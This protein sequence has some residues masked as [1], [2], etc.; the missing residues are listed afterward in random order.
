[1]NKDLGRFKVSQREMAVLQRYFPSTNAALL[2]VLC[3]PDSIP[4]EDCFWT[5]VLNFPWPLSK[6][7]PREVEEE[8]APFVAALA[9]NSGQTQAFPKL[10]NQLAKLLEAARPN[11]NNTMAVNAMYMV[12]SIVKVSVETLSTREARAMFEGRNLSE[13]YIKNTPGGVSKKLHSQTS[14]DVLPVHDVLQQAAQ[15]L[16]HI[17]FQLPSVTT[18]YL[19]QLEALQCLEVFM[20]TQLM[21]TSPS[22]SPGCH[23]FAEVIMQQASV[24]PQVV[25]RL[26]QMYVEASPVPPGCPLHLVVQDESSRA[27][28]SK[29]LL[30]RMGS[31]ASSM[32]SFPYRAATYVLRMGA[33]EGCSPISEASLRLLLLLIYYYPPSTRPPNPFRAALQNM[34]DLRF[35]SDLEQA[36][37]GVSAP[38]GD[39]N[40]GVDSEALTARP[41]ITFS[42]VYAALSRGLH[43]HAAVLLLYTLLAN[44]RAFKEHVLV[45]GEPQAVLLPLLELLYQATPV[46][47]DPTP[48]DMPGNEPCTYMILICVLLLSQDPVF[49]SNLYRTA[50]LGFVHW[51]KE[52]QV[53]GIT[54][55]SL[56]VLVLLRTAYHS[57]GNREGQDVYLATNSL[58]VLGNLAPHVSGLPS[59]AA[60]RFVAVYDLLRRRSQQL[61]KRSADEMQSPAAEQAASELSVTQEFLRIVLEV[62]N[63]MLVHGL[64]RNPELAYSLLHRQELFA[65]LAQHPRYGMLVANITAVVDYFNERVEVAR[66]Q[67]EWEWSVDN[68]LDVI[69]QDL[70]TWRSDRLHPAPSLQF[71]YEEH[72]PENFFV[73]HVWTLAVTSSLSGI[74]WNP[75]SIKLL[76]SVF[77]ETGQP[78]ASLTITCE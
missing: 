74:P 8:I 19:L 56:T 38:R 14:L 59:H 26:L 51:Y 66:A 28:N 21:S 57:I 29:G 70:R 48:S 54:L 4:P 73:P 39:A 67:H 37:P 16:L 36:N 24:A 65:D 68:V 10:L 13:P 49:A 20:S 43:S 32:L 45:C 64:P 3:G 9:C 11:T 53:T 69:Q 18:T 12:R 34:G 55:G 7:P 46:G 76:S 25:Q 22:E 31:A 33:D 50:T 1:M 17:L 47:S 6:W 42:G 77:M 78:H 23:T 44:N 58:A 62:I 41:V 60:Q 72:S 52:R 61:E 75:K 40:T 2:E 63:V 15:C 5:D 27:P 71:S 30:R 35:A